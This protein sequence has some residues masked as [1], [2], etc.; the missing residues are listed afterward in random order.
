MYELHLDI[1]MGDLWSDILRNNAFK[2]SYLRKKEYWILLKGGGMVT[3]WQWMTTKWT[4]K[5]TCHSVDWMVTERS[6]N[7]AFQFSRKKIVMCLFYD[8]LWY[9]NA[10]ISVESMILRWPLKALGILVWFEQLSPSIT[11]NLKEIEN[12]YTGNI[13]SNKRQW[14][15]DLRTNITRHA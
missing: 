4:L 6:L 14:F 9:A 1:I 5:C 15:N 10:N 8:N 13:K 12:D 11:Y 7:G 3:E 2:I